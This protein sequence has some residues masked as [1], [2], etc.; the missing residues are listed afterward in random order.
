MTE[1]FL[2]LAFLNQNEQIRVFYFTFSKFCDQSGTCKNLWL[3][4]GLLDADD[5]VGIYT[6]VRNPKY[7]LLQINPQMF[8]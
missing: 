4:L 7:Q 8:M 5:S 1:S 6:R 3:M 2:V